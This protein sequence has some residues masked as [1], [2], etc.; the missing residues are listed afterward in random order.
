[1]KKASFNL[2][3]HFR[4]CKHRIEMSSEDNSNA[5]FTSLK[6][7][8]SPIS[9][10]PAFTLRVFMSAIDGRTESLNCQTVKRSRKTTNTYI[11]FPP[12]SARIEDFPQVSSRR[13][14]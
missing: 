11:P 13:P 14:Y 4:I 7:P 2:V 5:L 8:E 10:R 6:T 12:E 3:A 9:S 1:M